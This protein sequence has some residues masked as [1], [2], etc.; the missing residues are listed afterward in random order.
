M[1]NPSG[2]SAVMLAF[3]TAILVLLLT[4][5]VPTSAQTSYASY[6]RF[7]FI[8]ISQRMKTRNSSGEEIANVNF[9][10]DDI[11]HALKKQ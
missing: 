4:L 5:T 2:V 11:V 10:Y 7:T 8:N 9:L 3:T 6:V 1:A